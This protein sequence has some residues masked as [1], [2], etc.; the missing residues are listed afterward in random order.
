MEAT[1]LEDWDALL[2]SGQK[3][4][5]INSNDFDG[6]AT[7]GDAQYNLGNYEQAL[8]FYK[9]TLMINEMDCHSTPQVAE[10][11]VEEIKVAEATETTLIGLEGV[12]VTDAGAIATI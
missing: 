1:K 9:K 3:M 12:L 6:W 5:E 7:V 4:I 2:V 10:M 8:K 11:V